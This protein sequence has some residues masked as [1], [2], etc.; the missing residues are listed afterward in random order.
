VERLLLADLPGDARHLDPGRVRRYAAV[1][2]E[3]PPVV[4]FRT[5]EGLLLADGWHR[6]AAARERGD[7][8]IAADVRTGTR[9]EA[10]RFA[11]HQGAAERGLP[12]AEVLARVLRHRPPEP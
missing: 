11:V 9:A 8:T 3:L 10:L 7:A 4:V 2:D 6:V 5:P 12:E 1:L